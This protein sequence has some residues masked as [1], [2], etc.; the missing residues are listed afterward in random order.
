MEEIDP[1]S[2]SGHG[3]AIFSEIISS[4]AAM[5]NLNTEEEN[6]IKNRTWKSGK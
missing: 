2:F 5:R 1:S 6:K 4:E 3:K